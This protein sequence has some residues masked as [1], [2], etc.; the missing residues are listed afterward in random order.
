MLRLRTGWCAIDVTAR[1]GGRRAGA[2]APK[3]KRD[4]AGSGDGSAAKAAL[5]SRNVGSVKLSKGGAGH[6]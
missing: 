4:F 3:L 1:A 2:A 6:M 5:S